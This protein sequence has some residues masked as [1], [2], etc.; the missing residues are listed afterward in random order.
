MCSPSAPVI[1][2]VHILSILNIVHNNFVCVVSFSFDAVEL[3][4]DKNTQKVK[5]PA[6]IIILN[7]K[8]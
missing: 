7:S 6:K 1:V 5:K 3:L 2:I 4:L 8:F